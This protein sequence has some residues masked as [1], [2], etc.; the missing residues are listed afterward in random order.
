MRGRVEQ[1][2]KGRRVSMPTATWAAFALA[3]ARGGAT[4]VVAVDES[5][6]ALEVGAECARRNGLVDRIRYVRSDA[7]ER[8]TSP[9]AKAASTSCSAIRRSSRRARARSTGALGA[10]Q[11]LCAA[12]C[13]A[14][15]PGG[16]LLVSSCSAAVGLE[17]LT[18]ALAI[19]ARDVNV[20]ATVSSAFSRVSITRCPPFSRGS[21]SEELLA[22]VEPA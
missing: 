2:A 1:L 15:K 6:L 9:A 4:E 14:T 16:L 8:M 20:R 3:A 18:R 22:V 5:A 13:R 10:Y 19:G 11:K 21:L 17:R 12:A 7:R